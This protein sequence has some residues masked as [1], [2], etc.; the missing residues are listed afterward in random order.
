MRSLRIAILLDV[1]VPNIAKAV[2]QNPLQNILATCFLDKFFA[3][4]L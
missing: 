4:D 3:I 1:Q 2:I